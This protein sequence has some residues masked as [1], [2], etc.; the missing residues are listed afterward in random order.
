MR[1]S[2]HRFERGALSRAIDTASLRESM[3]VC[4]VKSESL[5]ETMRV[6]RC[7]QPYAESVDDGMLKCRL[8]H[9]LPES[10]HRE[11]ARQ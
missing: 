3:R 11:T 7:E 9:E 1:L 10:G 2:P 5:V 4:L 6:A 8:D